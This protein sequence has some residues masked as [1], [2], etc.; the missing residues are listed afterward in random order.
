MSVNSAVS[1]GIVSLLVAAAPGLLQSPE[2]HFQE[3][4]YI[5]GQ[6]R[7]VMSWSLFSALQASFEVA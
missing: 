3:V 7:S 2:T 1:Q 4:C 6:V 5:A